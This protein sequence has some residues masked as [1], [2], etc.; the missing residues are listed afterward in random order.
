MIMRR[1]SV[2][3]AA[4]LLVACH[5]AT[6]GSAPRTTAQ[7]SGLKDAFRDAF[8]VGA[9]LSPRQ[10]EGRDTASVALVLRQFNATT[11]ENVLK[12]ERVHPEPDRYQFGPAD[13]Y[14]DFGARN[15]M[16]V[17]GHTLVWHNQTPRWVFQNAAGQPLSRDELLAR[18]K[19]H[20]STVV[21]RYKGRIKGWDVVNEALNDD[22]TV[23][24][25]QWLRIIGPDYIAKAFQFAHEADP[26]AQ[27]Y[28]NDYDLDYPAKRDGVIRLV[29]SL[30]AARI[31]IHAVGSQEHLKL[32]SPSIALV[33]SSIRMIAATGVKVNVTELDIDVLPAATRNATADVSVQAAPAPEIDPYKAGLP[34]SMQR[35]LA[36]RYEDLFRVYLAHHDAIDRVTFWGVAD[37]DS[38]LNG[39]P[40][41]GRTSYPLLFDRQNKP[42]PAFDRVM[43]LSRGTA[44]A[45]SS[46]PH[47]TDPRFDWFQYVGDDTVYRAMRAGPDE[48]HNPILAGFYPDPSMVRVGD[49]Y[50]LVVSSFAYFPGVPIFHSR[51]L[52]SWTQIGNV[53]DRPSQLNLDS[54]G[55]SRGVFAPAIRYRQGTFY[56]ITTV[57]DRGGNFFVTA[58]NPA[59]PWSDP[60]W[61]PELAGAIDPSFFFDD[62]GKAYVVNNGPPEGRPLYDGHRAIWMQEFDV[63][64]RRMVGPRRLIVN[65]GVD[66]VKK[67]IWIE[68]PHIFRKGGKYYLICAEGGTADQHSE[69]VFRSDSAWGPYVPFAGNPILT[70][71]HLDKNRPNAIGT[72]G[73][74][75]FV[76]TAN[77]EWWAVFLATRDYVDNVYN[78]GR[79]TFLMPVH[80]ENGWPGITSGNETVPY[81]AKRPNL[82]RQPAP[83]VPTSGNFTVRDEFDGPTLPPYWQVIRTPRV[84]T[85]DLTSAPGALTL[86][87]RPAGLETTSIPS[88]VGRRQQHQRFDASTEIRYR[89]AHD[90]EKA[91][92][93][94]FQ[95]ELYYYLLSVSRVE[96][97]TVVQL[98]KHAGRPS[99]DSGTVVA[100]A[101]I[102]ASRPIRLRIRGRSDRYDFLY[103]ERNEAWRTLA[104]DQDGRI[105][106]TAV[107]KGFVGTMLGLYATTAAR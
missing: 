24:Q 37:R 41:R 13:A 50:Y 19:E 18:M 25:S 45:R 65:G 12:W 103:S 32:D 66:L 67:P 92:I 68:A 20:I 39:W 44:S 64:G 104:A 35:A 46:A 94:A 14:V 40:V 79:E 99:G 21:G 48:Y 1:A 26:A 75:D 52:V 78:T 98:E 71:R 80:W 38:W 11:P 60:V 42:K 82:P 33:D 61:L 72:A 106:S 29:R 3:C 43:A 6:V 86:Y 88:F 22:G 63:A 107:A 62:D 17:I 47:A 70:Q 2:V 100:S 73:H 51:D 15:G 95:N 81:V 49:A 5:A 101:A 74:A 90:G 102:D 105:L 54:A 23:R 7:S 16:F 91:G 87:A 83:K 93:I 27:L 57:V 89:P 76:E 34:D 96:G 36:R 97:K 56:M 77:G 28:Y 59:G 10:F 31:P 53:L 4:L 8:M 30:Q 58:T 85:Y 84:Q 69:V 55:I 9:A